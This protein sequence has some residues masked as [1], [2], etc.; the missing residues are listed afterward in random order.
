MGKRKLSIKAHWENIYNTKLPT[1]MSWYQKY[2]SL[3]LKLI[4]TSGIEAKH[5]IIDVGGGTSLLVDSLLEK[6]FK[7]LAVLDISHSALDIAK[8][9]LGTRAENV[10]WY[11][12]DAT[13][14]QPPKQFDLWHDRAV[15]HFLTDEEAQ[16]KYVEVLKR[17][18]VSGGYLVIS[19]FAIDGPKKCSGRD[20]V[21]YEVS[22][23][24]AKLGGEF[25]LLEF[26][27]E[28]HI[29]PGKKE[30]KFTYFLYKRS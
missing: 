8:S 2:P 17:T 13:E 18:L 24:S 20:T 29:T 12:A 16:R 22:S 1:E 7:R 21:K 19:T 3:S 23:M 11:E 6:G 30:Q 15:F 10:K 25:R 9:R 5:S 28:L 27:D 26:L 4:K 14:F